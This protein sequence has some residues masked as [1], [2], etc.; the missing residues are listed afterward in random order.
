MFS[1]LR[2]DNISF[3]LFIPRNFI[4]IFMKCYFT[5]FTCYFMSCYISEKFWNWRN[6]FFQKVFFFLFPH[7]FF[8]FLIIFFSV[9]NV[10]HILYLY[11]FY[12][13]SYHK[14]SFSI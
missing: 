5:Y 6:K 10:I 12:T 13:F 4:F 8:F 11:L 1:F 14:N 9:H 7:M 3:Y 2:G